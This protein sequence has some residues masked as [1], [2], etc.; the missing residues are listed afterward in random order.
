MAE[1]KGVN[2]TGFFKNITN[3]LPYQALDLNHQLQPH[4]THNI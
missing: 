2:Q 3:K 1:D 4:L